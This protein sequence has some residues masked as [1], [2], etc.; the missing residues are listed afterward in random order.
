MRKSAKRMQDIINDLLVLGRAG[1]MELEK[2]SVD[3]SSIVTEITEVLQSQQ[4]DRKIEIVIQSNITAVCDKRL[5]RI[6]LENLIG[7]SWKYTSKT[8]NARIEFSSI[9][10]E[11][12]TI[13]CVS[14]NGVGFEM[15]FADKLFTPF[16]RLHDASAFPGT[17]IGLA[18]THKIIS[19][20][21]GKIWAES[22]PGQGAKFYFT[23]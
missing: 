8:E 10:K 15:K 17:G 23:L 5:I 21:G 19:R 12:Q 6:V 20:H 16:K 18:T 11:Q 7:N 22:I 9:T 14:D 2:N 4:P 3:L 13:Y 1:Q